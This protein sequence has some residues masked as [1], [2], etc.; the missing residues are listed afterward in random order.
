MKIYLYLSLSLIY[1][2]QT[3]H[4]SPYARLNK[5]AYQQHCCFLIQYCKNKP[6][7]STSVVLER[8]R[9]VVNSTHYVWAPHLFDMCVLSPQTRHNPKHT[10]HHTVK[11]NEKPRVI[12]LV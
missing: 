2:F 5:P 12:H 11:T 1:P 4:L 6:L 8:E 3:P 9:S 7:V 10:H